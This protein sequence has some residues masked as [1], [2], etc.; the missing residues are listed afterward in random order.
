MLFRVDVSVNKP[1]AIC[2]AP[3]R[4]LARQIMSVVKAMGKFT[5]ISTFLGV[6]GVEVE[7]GS[8][9]SE[10]IVVGTPGRVESLIKKRLLDTSQLKVSM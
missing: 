1:Q 9:I 8:T 4:E 2:L 10:Q 3:T 5:G 7:R 6:P